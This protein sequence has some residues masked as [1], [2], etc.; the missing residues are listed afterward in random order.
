MT[1]TAEAA[2]ASPGGGASSPTIPQP[3]TPRELEIL[4][5][6]VADLSDRQIAE[7]LF[8]SVRTVEG[9]VAR[10]LAKLGVRTRAAAVKAAITAGLVDVDPPVSRAPPH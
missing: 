2:G 6:L 3:L 7:T 5:L 9:H 8:V 10:I 1:V 4:C